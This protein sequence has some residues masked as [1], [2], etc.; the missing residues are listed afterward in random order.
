[1]QQNAASAPLGDAVSN[2]YQVQ[3]PFVAPDTYS[4]TLEYIV[5]AQ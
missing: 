2:D 4:A 1:H 3:I 5:S